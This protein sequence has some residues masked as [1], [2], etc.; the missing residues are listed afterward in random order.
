M[1]LRCPDDRAKAPGTPTPHEHY[2]PLVESLLV[3]T[4]IVGRRA[5]DLCAQPGQPLVGLSPLDV[6]LLTSLR[7]VP[8]SC[9]VRPEEFH[10]GQVRP[11]VAQAVRD[12]LVGDVSR[13]IDREAVLAESLL[14]RARLE[15][16]EVDGASGELPE[17]AVEVARAV[18]ILKADDGGA[19]VPRRR[20]DAGRADGDEAGLIALEVLH[21]LGEDHEPVEVGREAWCDHGCVG[22]GMGTELASRVRGRVR[23]KGFHS[24]QLLGEE[25]AALRERH[26]IGHDAAHIPERRPSRRHE[27]E[28]DVEHHLTLDEEIDVEDQRVEGVAHHPVDRVLHR[29]EAEVGRSRAHRLEDVADR[30]HGLEHRGGVVRLR[31][32]GLL[33]EGPERPEEGDRGGWTGRWGIGCARRA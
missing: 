18:R 26:G 15:P 30:V 20:R 4:L 14:R 21:V 12:D 7:G 3:S 27:V 19:V 31:E 28:P 11:K 17:D 24:G 32:E 2:V 25:P 8:A 22:V 33:G 29:D 16:R 10:I 9:G 13:Q 1:A 5:D 6:D 23:R